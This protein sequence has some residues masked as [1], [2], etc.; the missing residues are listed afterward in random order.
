MLYIIGVMDETQPDFLYEKI[1]GNIRRIRA[2]IASAAS[3]A[4]RRPEEITLVAASKTVN[5]TAVRAAI[6]SGVTVMGES[7]IQEALTKFRE[8]GSATQWHFIG[9]LQK[10]KVKFIF[11][12]F[13][14]VHSVDSIELAT[15]INR[16]AETRLAPNK[17]VHI[18]LQLNIAQEESK[19]GIK[20]L[21]ALKTATAISNLPRVR[22]EGL[23]AIP[24]AGGASHSRR[25]FRKL[26]KI[27]NEIDRLGLENV[28]MRKF[29]FGMTNDYETAV[30]EGATHVRIGSG[31]FG[32]R[33]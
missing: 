14:L 28:S 25:Y 33:K 6:K 8:I 16:R 23:M 19:Y 30:E 11:G 12:A 17:K 1:S 24:P 26:M 9:H 21:D 3:R 29:S 31:I 10:N 2:N 7:K 4:G 32:D 18:L 5:A 13:S 22:I 20:P 27:K 15:E